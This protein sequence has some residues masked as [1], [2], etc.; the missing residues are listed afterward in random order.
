MSTAANK[1]LMT[2]IYDELAKGNR[3]PV[4]NAMA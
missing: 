4:R 3:M 1:E 2:E